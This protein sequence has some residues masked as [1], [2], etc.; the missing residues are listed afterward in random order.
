MNTPDRR[1]PDRRSDRRA[2]DQ[3]REETNDLL[4]YWDVVRRYWL[5]ILSLSSCITLISLLLV[6]KMVPI[7]QA[8]ASL[9]IDTREEKLVSVQNLYTQDTTSH[10]YLQSQFEILKSRDLAER[11][12]QSLS[13]AELP[14]FRQ[15]S[16]ANKFD[17]RKWLPFG[18]SVP[19]SSVDAAASSEKARERV[20]GWFQGALSI[21]PVRNTQIVKVCFEDRDPKLAML[22]A[23][24]AGEAFIEGDLNSKLAQ[25]QQAS[26]WLSSRLDGLKEQLTQSEQRLQTFLEY[27]HLIDLEGVYTLATKEVVS[28]TEKLVQ[29][30][31][32]RAEAEN[33][34]RQVAS[35]SNLSDA[36]VES[37]PDVGGDVVLND[38]KRKLM[39]VQ[40][41]YSEFS[42]QLG[43]S[44]P[45][46]QSLTAEI[47]SLTNAMQQHVLALKSRL[48]NQYEIVAAN[49]Q[50][51]ESAIRDNKEEIQSISRKQARWKELKRDV[52][53]NQQLYDMFLT[54]MKEMRETGELQTANSHFIDRAGVPQRPVK[55]KKTQLIILAF[56][57][58]VVFSILG[59]LLLDNIDTSIKI[60]DALESRITTRLLGTLPLLDAAKIKPG[61]VY[62]ENKHAGFCESVRTLRTGIMLSCLDNPYQVIMVTSPIGGEGKTTVAINLAFAISQTKNQ[63]VLLLEADMRK[64]K[65][66]ELLGLS[67]R[68]T[69]LSNV[70]LDSLALDE[71]LV[72]LRYESGILDILTSG[73]PPPDILEILGSERFSEVLQELKAHYDVILIDA[74]AVQR[75]SDALV[76]SR[77][78]DAIVYVVK[79]GVTSF[80][81]AREGIA[82]LRNKAQGN[83]CGVVLNCVSET[84]PHLSMLARMKL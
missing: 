76:L 27:E 22:I 71:A 6:L 77:E 17:W 37:L 53:S 40:T 11:V 73:A 34:Y 80:K 46:M 9:M 13:L 38:L 47:T 81:A 69:G 36:R 51:L 70:L 57:G 14:R 41:Q 43:V 26:E 24:A 32:Q 62:L 52:N 67:Q 18:V 56:L 61:L 30:R 72:R 42:K 12:I 28:L 83:I 49:E 82:R 8:E 65:I 21:N 15:E 78:A 23:N 75:V 5:G 48:K 4:Q 20:I 54:R 63:K 33:L 1:S 25:A 79:A 2:S 19:Q 7:Y 35:I 64:P 16:S 74:P 3:P 59:A 44:H 68:K 50:A 55:P 10:E 66:A 60:S 31:Q 45:K 84:K 39:E 58:G 29:V